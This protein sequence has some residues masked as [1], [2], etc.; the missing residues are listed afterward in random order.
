MM[1]YLVGWKGVP[2]AAVNRAAI[3]VPPDLLLLRWQLL[4]TCRERGPVIIVLSLQIK[5]GPSCSSTVLE[6]CRDLHPVTSSRAMMPDRF[7]RYCR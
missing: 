3:S 2:A 1:L 6:A 4:A 7:I 5:D